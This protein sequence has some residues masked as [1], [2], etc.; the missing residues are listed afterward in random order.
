MS[1]TNAR[2]VAQAAYA[3]CAEMMRDPKLSPVVL[4]GLSICYGPVMFRPRLALITFQGGGADPTFQ[5]EAP[6]DLLY[7]SDP[8]RFGSAVRKY[9]GLTGLTDVLNMSTISHP[10]VFPQ[11]PTRDAPKWERNGGAYSA[12]RQTSLNWLSELLAAQDP[13]VIMVFGDKAARLL[14]LDW[15]DEEF[16]HVQGH[17]TFARAQWNGRPAI[18]CHHLSIG[19]PAEAALRA[20]SEARHLIEETA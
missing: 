11:A 4:H 9:A 7:K 14:G 6:D 17:R 2:T 20:F 5:R 16:S 10:V 1:L 13:K 19:C 12:W 8:Y 15:T 3:A 18:F